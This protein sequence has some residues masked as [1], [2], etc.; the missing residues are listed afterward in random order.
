MDIRPGSV[1]AMYRHYNIPKKAPLSRDERALKQYSGVF[2]LSNQIVK[3]GRVLAL[4]KYQN[5]PRLAGFKTNP[6]QTSTWGPLYS[7]GDGKVW[8]GIYAT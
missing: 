1:S 3:F 6:R 2:Q 7:K 8:E 5:I 4:Y